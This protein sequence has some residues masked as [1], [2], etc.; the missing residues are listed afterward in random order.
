LSASEDKTIKI[1]DIEKRRNIL[2]IDAGEKINS[3]RF[4]PDETKILAGGASKV[5]KIYNV[6]DGSKFR[7]LKGHEGAITVI[8]WYTDD[9]S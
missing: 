6:K 5:V 8:R 9:A 2:T 1:W 7:F 4:S 3:V